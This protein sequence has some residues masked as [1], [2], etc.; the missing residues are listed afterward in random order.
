MTSIDSHNDLKRVAMNALTDFGKPAVMP[1]VEILNNWEGRYIAEAALIRIGKPSISPVISVLD[2]K[3][4]NGLAVTILVN[5]GA[6]AQSLLM[7]VMENG[8]KSFS[9]RAAWALSFFKDLRAVPTLIEA[10]QKGDRRMR[11]DA[12]YALG[13]LGDAKAVPALSGFL[14]HG[15]DQGERLD[16][17]MSLAKIGEASKAPLVD[18]LEN[19][20]ENARWCAAR[21]LAEL[22]DDRASQPL[23]EALERGDGEMKEIAIWG[24]CSM[25]DAKAVFVLAGALKREKEASFQKQLA[26]ALGSIAKDSNLFIPYISN[27]LNEHRERKIAEKR[28]ILDSAR[29]DR[30][31]YY[32]DDLGFYLK[33]LR[34]ISD[35][36]NPKGDGLLLDGKIKPPRSNGDASPQAKKAAIR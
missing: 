19:G 18:V 2:D 17:A 24:L 29:L 8:F 30:L 7:D 3:E 5:I 26:Q 23:N 6:P 14:T 1:L 34:E 16:A 35:A 22:G 21:G 9:W 12:I 36:K 27:S 11:R 33:K 4:R 25:G 32:I 10:A 15:E 13:E 20:A 28:G 31:D